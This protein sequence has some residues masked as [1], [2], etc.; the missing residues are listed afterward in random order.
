[1]KRSVFF[2]IT[3]ILGAIFGGMMLFVPDKAAAGFGIVSSP[4]TSMFFRLIGGMVFSAGFLNFLVRNHQDSGTLKAVLLFNIV[5]H[6]IG[7]INDSIAVLSGVLDFLKISSGLLIH[8]FV[9][10]GSIIYLLQIKS[11]NK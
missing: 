7:L 4:E 3:A 9:G 8:L 5:F 11:T 10:I 6:A 1:M 2:I